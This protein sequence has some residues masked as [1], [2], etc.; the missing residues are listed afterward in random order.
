MKFSNIDLILFASTS[1][2]VSQIN[3]INNYLKNYLKN[4]WNWNSKYTFYNY[5]F[6]FSYYRLKQTGLYAILFI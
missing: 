5:H 6:N 1:R 2:I 3:A 4:I